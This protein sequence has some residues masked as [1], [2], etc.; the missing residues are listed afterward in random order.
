MSCDCREPETESQNYTGTKTLT[1]GTGTWLWMS[2]EVLLR[3]R[4]P[5]DRAGAL[6]V[7]RFV[8]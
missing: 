1:A 5:L 7:Y 3:A 4:I 2:P 8:V 6:D